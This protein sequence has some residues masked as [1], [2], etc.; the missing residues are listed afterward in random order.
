MRSQDSSIASLLS[1]L[2]ARLQPLSDTPR[3]DAQVLLAYILDKPR[4]WLLS[5]PDEFLTPSQEK[6]FALAAS[7]LVAGE[8]LPYVIGHWEFY[9]LDFQVNP[10]VLI[11]RPETELLI[12]HAL[13][14]LRSHPK[15]RWAA[16]IG[17]GSGCIAVS[18]AAKL[19][20]LQVLASDISLP[21]LSVAKTNAR[22][23]GVAGRIEFIQA[24]LL[25]FAPAA[26]FD[27]I[28][29]NLPYIPTASLPTLSIPNHEPILALDGGINGLEL[30]HR[31]LLQARGCL[32]VGGLMLLEIEATEGLH[33]QAL[34]CNIF[35]DAQV[36]VYPDLAGHDRLLEI[37]LSD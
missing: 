33:V 10:H 31:M 16:D 2:Q 27:L 32:A 17:T 19:P 14:W 18:M 6:N 34:A 35:K 22:K 5:H 7:R 30:I 12:E 26:P 28:C 1:D 25:D 11:P 36:L 21:A 9:G 20:D 13:D 15:R 37:Q 8:P 3:L 29:A 4:P 24:D 23:H